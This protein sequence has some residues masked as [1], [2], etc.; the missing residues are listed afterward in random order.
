[1]RYR[2]DECGL[3]RLTTP[4]LMC[5]PD[6]FVIYK[7]DIAVKQ[8][9][10]PK[11]NTDMNTHLDSAGRGEL[12]KISASARPGVITV[13]TGDR[14]ARAFVTSYKRNGKDCTLWMF[15]AFL[16]VNP[17]SAYFS[18]LNKDLV[19]LA[20]DF[21]SIIMNLDKQA[22]T[23]SGRSRNALQKR[24][25]ESLEHMLE[26]VL[27][28]KTE[29][30]NW[31]VGESLD[32]LRH[33]L[34]DLLAGYGY[35]VDYHEDVTSGHKRKYLNFR[36]FLIFYS[37]A[38]TFCC[39]LTRNRKVT[40]DVKSAEGSNMIEFRIR[41][42]MLFPPV[43]TDG[44]EGNIRAL[45]S[46]VP[47]HQVEILLF[48]KLVKFCGYEVFYTFTDKPRDN[49]EFLF[50]VPLTVSRGFSAPLSQDWESRLMPT[51]CD[52]Y[53]KCMLLFSNFPVGF[54]P[55]SELLDE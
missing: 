15:P 48:D 43:Y 17:S 55:E 42:T 16:Q 45:E 5:G 1:M 44:A 38:L 3:D 46:V 39:E 2:T 11:R 14:D 33:Q 28:T 4:I 37:H 40:L 20:P 50:R 52:Y 23:S 34:R 26:N 35:Q 10:L 32:I 31:L 30:A 19:K 51:D 18:A 54:E 53:L 8:I 27:A 47:D 21:C 9:R 25:G 29:R 41:F 36:D 7:N 22:H 49:V 12:A 24:M 13:Y 6:G